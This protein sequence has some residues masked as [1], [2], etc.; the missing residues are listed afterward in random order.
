M[1]A[2]ALNDLW[3][4][5]IIEELVR[6]GTG[7]FIISPGSRSTPLV[8][9]AANHPNVQTLIHPDE[10][11]AAFYALGYAKATGRP[12]VLICTSGTALVNYYPAIVEASRSVLPMIILSSDRPVELRGT[13]APQTIDQVKIF[14]G[15][16]RWSFDL[17]A[18]DTQ[19][20]PSFVLTT[21]DQA[22]FRTIR[23]PAGPVQINCMYREPFIPVANEKID[24]AQFRSLDKWLRHANPYTQYAR[25]TVTVNEPKLQSIALK[26]RQSKRGLL[27]AGT[28]ETDANTNQIDRLAGLLSWPVC[29]DI[30]SGLR[31]GSQSAPLSVCHHDLYLRVPEIRASFLPDLILHLGGMPVSKYL[32]QL[33]AESH[34]DYILIDNHPFRHDPEH[35]VTERIECS[36]NFFAEQ[37]IPHVQRGTSE[38]T[39]P[40]QQVESLCRETLQYYSHRAANLS[41]WNIVRQVF[42][43]APPESGIFLA[44]SM[45][46]RDGNA[47]ASGQ[48]YPLIVGTNRGANGID[49][50]VASTIGFGAGL[51]KLTTLLIGDLAMLHDINSLALL[52]HHD[53]PVII[54]ILNNDGGGIFSFLSVAQEQ[55]HFEEYFGTPHGLNFQKAAEMYTINYSAPHN[56]QEFGSAYTNA[57]QNQQ[58]TIIEIQS[59]RAQ[60]VTEHEHI[61]KRISKVIKEKNPANR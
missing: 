48:Q 39:K 28:M 59:T 38:L 6:S 4:T 49:G 37:I 31:F 47:F 5:L 12:A 16:L 33:I 13:G 42:E 41:E 9:A 40:F 32:P 50:T 18:P 46:V 26:I 52:N 36:P 29:A 34:A 19:I 45:P 25:P 20:D 51:N 14:G 58:T 57:V 53:Q 17:P 61:W 44:N 23:P 7:R 24:P 15:Y 2:A 3:A 35:C 21:V 60:N 8:L 1:S 30:S 10:R 22:L 55:S 54:I 56:M 27:I 43:H 11:G